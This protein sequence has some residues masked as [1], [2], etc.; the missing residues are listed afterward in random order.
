MSSRVG[1]GRMSWEDF[2]IHMQNQFGPKW[3][4]EVPSSSQLERGVDDTVD[5]ASAKGIYNQATDERRAREIQLLKGSEWQPKNDP[6][7][8][9]RL[10]LEMGAEFGE[11]WQT[12]IHPKI[13]DQLNQFPPFKKI[14]LVSHEILS[15]MMKNKFGDNW[16]KHINWDSAEQELREA[17]P[18]SISAFVERIESLP[19]TSTMPEEE[20]VEKEK[21]L[22]DQ[23]SLAVSEIQWTDK[24]IPSAFV[25]SMKGIFRASQAATRKSS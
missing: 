16:R 18:D 20:R 13:R 17:G 22:D 12:K 1:E 5:F 8:M 24:S 3:Q 9:E 4:K 19:A 7:C 11:N 23:A 21:E 6:Y 25:R 15:S 2:S 14:Q 10:D